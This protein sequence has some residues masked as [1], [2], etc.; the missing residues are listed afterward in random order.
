MRREFDGLD[1]LNAYVGAEAFGCAGIPA[2]FRDV[3]AMYDA[4][5]RVGAPPGSW[6]HEA[7][8]VG[9]PRPCETMVRGEDAWGDPVPLL[10][11]GRWC[12]FDGGADVD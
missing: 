2:E 7:F 12:L 6:A 3:D 5:L 4:F 11:C 1:L 9:S 10:T 8:V